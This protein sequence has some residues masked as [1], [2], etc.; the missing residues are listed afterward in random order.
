MIVGWA[1]ELIEIHDT[2]AIVT[3]VKIELLAGVMSQLEG[4]RT[5]QYLACFDCVDKGDIRSQDW[6]DAERIASRVP[7]NPQPR[8]LGDCLIRA[9]ANLL[10]YDVLTRD[11]GFPR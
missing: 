8:Q 3:P 10:R 6:V 2:N 7:H 9:I 1:E 11:L 5:R 4:E